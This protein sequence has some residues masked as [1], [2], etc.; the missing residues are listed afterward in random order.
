MLITIAVGKHAK[1]ILFGGILVVVFT[2]LS[3]VLFKMIAKINKS[4]I[5]RGLLGTA[6]IGLMIAGISGAM[7]VFGAFLK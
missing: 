3:I 5:I 7:M 6:A 2:A 1:D 4:T